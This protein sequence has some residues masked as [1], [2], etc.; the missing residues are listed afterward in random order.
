MRPAVE[1]EDPVVEVL[2]AE[3]EPRDPHARGSPRSFA[4]VSVPGSH[5]NVISSAPAHGVAAVSRVDEPLELRG[6]E[7]R[8]RAAAE[9][10]EVERTAG[11][12]R[13]RRIELPLARQA[14]EIRLHLA[15][16]PFGVDA[17]V[18]EMTLLPAER[19]VQVEAQRHSGRGAG[20]RRTADSVD[21][22]GGPH[23]KRRVIRDEVA[24]DLGLVEGGGTGVPTYSLL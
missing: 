16:V 8:R 14:I 21:G 5:S 6:R 17:E 1:L 4:S 18:T 20:Q 9:I 19:D 10:H 3:T 11:D 2:D 22:F 13:R 15:R 23:R 12:R 7:E 24:A